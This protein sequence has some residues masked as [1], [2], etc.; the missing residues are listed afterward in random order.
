MPVEPT[1][2]MI[3]AG[4]DQW[5]DGKAEGEIYRAM[6]AASPAPPIPEGIEALVREVERR[7]IDHEW[8]PYEGLRTHP[9][10][11]LDA[12]SD[13]DL[14]TRLADA[15]EARGRPIAA[16]TPSDVVR[17]GHR[18]ADPGCQTWTLNERCIEHTKEHP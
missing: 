5:D 13:R 1:E 11:P 4:C 18:C 9:L 17:D 7:R 10:F 15:L 14:I 12:L 16:P 3:S 8:A 6:L 2:E